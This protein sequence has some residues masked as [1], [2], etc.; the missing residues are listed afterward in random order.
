MSWC[1]AGWLGLGLEGGGGEP[2]VDVDGWDA[3]T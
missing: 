2:S 3:A 1:G